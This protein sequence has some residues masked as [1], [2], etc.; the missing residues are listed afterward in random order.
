MNLTVRLDKENQRFFATIDGVDNEI[1][2]RR[3]GPKLFEFNGM[4]INQEFE[5]KEIEEELL[6]NA[7]LFAQKEGIKVIPGCDKVSGYLSKHK[8]FT[9]VTVL[10][11]S[12]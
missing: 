10:E 11:Q 6:F 3:I 2:Y 5:D 12:A 7:F 8:E 1:R 4:N 9:C